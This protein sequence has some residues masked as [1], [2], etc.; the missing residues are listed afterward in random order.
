MASELSLPLL[1]A[2][3]GLNSSIAVL[4]G[5]SLSTLWIRAGRSSWSSH[6]LVR[7][8]AVAQTAFAAAMF[9]SIVL[10]LLEA[11][12]MAEVP[13]M[14]AA[15]A[16]YSVLTATHYGFAWAIGICALATVALVSVLRWRPSHARAA[17]WLRLL[18]IGV[19]LYSRSIV[20]HAGAGG[21]I[22]WAVAAD[23]FHLV[24]ISLWIGEVFIA[25]VVTLRRPAGS[26]N[27]ARPER[28][29]YIQDLSN[30]ATVALVGIFATGLVS[31]W[32]GLGAI[33]NATGNPYATTL[34]IK[35][36]L[37]ATAAMLGGVNRFFVMPSLLAHLR[38]TTATSTNAEHRFA[39]VLKIE[40]V[41]LFAALIAAAVLSSTSPPTAS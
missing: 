10:L 5:A 15:P 12:A 4:T 27:H 31:A 41:V 35:L 33:E 32:R 17:D 19:F 37:V 3:V 39:L 18:A 13:L 20:S 7:L 38:S 21:D 8:R 2:T 1:A 11:A 30:S 16:V 9:S 40:M 6:N 29:R 26:V 24:L 22:S 25:A 23:W 34:L 28:A 36:G 14:S